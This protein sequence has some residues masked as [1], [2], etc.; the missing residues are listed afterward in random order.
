MYTFVKCLRSLAQVKC[1]QKGV[2]FLRG[3]SLL[4][5]YTLS[6][7]N[8][9]LYHIISPIGLMVQYVFS[10]NVSYLHNQSFEIILSSPIGLSEYVTFSFLKQ[11]KWTTRFKL[12]YTMFIVQEVVPV[13]INH[14]SYVAILFVFCMY[15][16]NMH[17]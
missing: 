8:D 13:Y 4:K 15:V 16:R 7:L 9:L 10:W 12:S 3:Q 5:I 17:S 6:V 11:R 1:T 14:K 2:P